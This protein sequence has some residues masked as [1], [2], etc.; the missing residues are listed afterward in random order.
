MFWRDEFNFSVNLPLADAPISHVRASLVTVAR[1][2][3]A[4]FPS[5][6]A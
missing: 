6:A 3:W 2:Q 1:E 5:A 4:R